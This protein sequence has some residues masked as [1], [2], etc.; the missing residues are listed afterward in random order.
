MVNTF[1]PCQEAGILEIGEFLAAK[2]ETYM[3]LSGQAGVG[4][5]TVLN[6]IPALDNAHMTAM[7]NKAANVLGGTT[8]DKH[9]GLFPRKD[10][11]T[12]KSYRTKSGGKGNAYQKEI[13]IIDEA[14]Q[15]DGNALKLVDELTEDCKIILSCDR[16]QIGPVGAKCPIF[17]LGFRTLDMVTPMRQ[18]ADSDLYKLCTALRNGVKTGTLV[19]LVENDNVTYIDDDETAEFLANMTVDDKSVAYTNDT[20]VH[21]NNCTRSLKGVDGFWKVGETLVSN[22]IIEKDKQIVLGNEEELTVVGVGAKL[23]QNSFGLDC[24]ETETTRGDFLVPVDS[25]AQTQLLKQLAKRKEWREY[26]TLRDTVPDLRG[27]WAVTGHKSQGST[28]NNVLVHLPDIATCSRWDY[29]LF[30][31]ILYVAIS[32]AKGQVYLYGSL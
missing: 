25:D 9:F 22:G 31:R 18:G 15:L 5:T 30:L 12:G 16:Y 23:V 19:D 13:I 24:Y 28:Y 14:S 2:D 32:R 6:H 1:S 3:I 29:D 10:F 11:K 4:K 8:L 7:S 27:T 20:A 21:I 17:D 26:Y